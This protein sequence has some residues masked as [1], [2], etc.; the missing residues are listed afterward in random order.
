MK[1]FRLIVITLFLWS[2][3]VFSQENSIKHT[4]VKGETISS[5]AQKYNV[6]ITSIYKLNPK[7]KKTLQLNQVLLIPN[8]E[9]KKTNNLATADSEQ[10]IEINHQVL[11]KET[12]YGITKQFKTTAELLYK[13]N[14]KL[15]SEGLKVGQTII[16]PSSLSKREIAS[17]PNSKIAE[18]TETASPLKHQV[19]P[20]E[21]L[22][23]IAKMYGV[24]LKEIQSA[25]PEIGNKG[26]SIG[27]T[28]F[29]PSNGKIPENAVVTEEKKFEIK[30]VPVLGAKTAIPVITENTTKA[31]E[32][33]IESDIQMAE[34]VHE[35][36]T[37]ETKYGIAKKYG[38]TV[39][40][41]EKQNPTIKE[42]LLVGSKL[43]IQAPT[44]KIDFKTENVLVE[45]KEEVQKEKEEEVA[46]ASGDAVNAGLIDQI[47]EFASENIGVKY[48]SGGTT[49][50]GFD[51]SGLIYSAF[52]AFDIKLP[53][54]SIEQSSTGEKIN[55]VDAQKGDLIFFKTNGRH[56][57]NHVGMVIE[58]SED[59]IK[60]IHSST[61][62]GVIISSTKEPYYQR[63]FAQ[64]N[65]VVK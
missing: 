56:H 3:N 2:I 9:S 36:L 45:A 28:I 47:I 13:A 59:E 43:S 64:V 27:Q 44:D 16:I 35:V 61:H 50:S 58:V 49:A 25:N 34:V 40:E 19:Q 20:K 52:G 6:S 41:L 29:I 7:A 38:I 32:V 62:S 48:R 65:R 39:A 30:E 53:R 4:I 26:L 1:Y 31:K 11:P 57:I 23:F 37:K 51:C 22:Y 55:D 54:T 46:N 14:P 15:E 17:L 5:I 60:F 8:S 63:N 21:S 33:K 24:S 12:L 18:V 42:K 10:T